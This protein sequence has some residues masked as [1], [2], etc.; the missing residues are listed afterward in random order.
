MTENSSLRLKLHGIFLKKVEVLW[1]FL[2]NLSGE[3]MRWS[4]DIAD[5]RV[6][7]FFFLFCVK[8]KKIARRLGAQ[9]HFNL[10]TQAK[11]KALCKG[12]P[13]ISFTWNAQYH[14]LIKIVTQLL[15]PHYPSIIEA[16]TSII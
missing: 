5:N 12:Y 8:S 2:H 7:Y 16:D 15:Y 4:K 10:N 13:E 11:N 9:T 3:K 1:K 14:I 6:T